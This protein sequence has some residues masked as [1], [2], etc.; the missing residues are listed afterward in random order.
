MITNLPFQKDYE[1]YRAQWEKIN[2]QIDENIEKYRKADA[3]VQVVDASGAPVTDA[4]VSLRQDTHDFIFGCN[5]LM[6][7]GLGDQEEVYQ[8]SFARLFNLVTT[9]LCWAETEFEPD[10][11]RFEEGVKE[12]FR[13]PPIDRMIAFAKKYNLK[14]KGQPLFCERWCPAWSS[15]E[16]E[17]LKKQIKNYFC[18][19]A[20]HCGEH[21]DIVDVINEAFCAPR[22]SPD[23]PLLDEEFSM[24][25]WAFEAV[26]GVFP[27]HVDLELNEASHVNDRLTE[28]YYQAAKRLMD[29][30]L[31]IKS[32]GIQ[33]HMF[34]PEAGMAH[35]RDEK[36]GLSDILPAY[37]RFN[38]L[39]LPL[40]IS[41]VTIPSTFEGTRQQGEALQ[42]EM[43]RN[44]YRLWFSIE[45]MAGIIYWNF[46][47]GLAWQTEGDCLGCLMDQ[48]F[49]EKPSYHAL[50]QLI[51][52]EWMT[53]HHAL[54][55]EN[56]MV[57]LRG[58]KGEYTVTVEK[59]GQTV[60]GK[61]HVGKD[62]KLQIV[63]V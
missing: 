43:A 52:R 57:Q 63:L 17:E 29:K 58:F 33:Y 9:T 4:K 12:I 60:K 1:A 47:D 5:G 23:F 50:Y 32:L 2:P 20:E 31:P 36:R 44:L 16:P 13:R 35:L 27:E 10:T 38:Q 37:E 22:R 34:T 6:V 39:G 11:F 55:D 3:C 59:N 45:N 25:D 21:L 40:F 7:G 54:S 49:K 26:K 41:E 19:V 42:A 62:N 18:K 28:Q 30:K 15:K 56:G 48:N 14:L 51:R 53:N 61:L 24:I 46:K 8:E